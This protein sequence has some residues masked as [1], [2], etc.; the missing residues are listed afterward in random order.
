M[1]VYLDDVEAR[2]YCWIYANMMLT[3]KWLLRDHYF[4]MVRAMTPQ[5][6]GR[7]LA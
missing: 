6:A 7:C 4:G 5:F 2:E 3:G 1:I